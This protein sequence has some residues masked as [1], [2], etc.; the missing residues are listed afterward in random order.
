[1]TNILDKAD[2]VEPTYTDDSICI[3]EP[4]NGTCEVLRDGLVIF[5]GMLERYNAYKHTKS[6][7]IILNLLC[8]YV[9]AAIQMIYFSFYLNNN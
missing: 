3:Q 8:V 1:M 2:D 5:I 9:Y 7:D 6:T 4:E